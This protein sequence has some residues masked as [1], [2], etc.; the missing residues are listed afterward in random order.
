MALRWVWT[1]GGVA[2]LL[3]T[4]WG[5]G[6]PESEPAEAATGAGPA[7]GSQTGGTSSGGAQS[8]GTGTGGASTG[9][10]PTGGASTGGTS[11]G[12]SSG[13]SPT[14][15]ASTGGVPTGGASTGGAAAGGTSS[16]GT[17]TGGAPAG[18]T[19][20]GGVPTG[21]A[22]TGGT[23]TGGSSTGGTDTGGAGTGGAPIG[24]APTGGTNTGGA[25]TGG[26]STGGTTTGGSGGNLTVPFILGADISNTQQSTA[27]YRDTD[28]QEKSIFDLLK[29]HGFN[30]VRL[31]TF[32][33][34]MAPYGY[35]SN[36]NGCSGLSEAFGDKAHV[37]AYGKQVKDAGMGFLLDFHYSDNWADPGNQIIPDP[38]RD[39]A[40]VDALATLVKDYTKDVI[41]SAIAAGARP[42]M[43]QIGNE[44]TPGMLVHLPGPD[45]DCWGNN[46]VNA[47][48][49]GSSSS[50]N[51]DNLAKLLGAGIA[52]VR[53]VDPAIEIVLHIE[54]HGA[55]DWWV[56]EAVRRNVDFDILGLSCYVAFQGQPSVWQATFED[57]ASN[58]AYDHLDFIIAEYNPERTQANLIMKNLPDGR[59]RGTF[60]WEPTGSGEWGEAMFTWSGGV[61]VAN[62]DDFAEYDALLPQLGL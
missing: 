17:A 56:G 52:G 58:S 2:L 18:G 31:K 8:G 38:W 5:C 25:E 11:A 45:T 34:P 61:A 36:A 44:I 54:N 53:E 7:G 27:R 13:G 14:G 39:A 59:G 21:G 46:V 10:N 33:D 4:A 32:V 26:T 57:L 19:S 16:G 6:E 3:G 42:D 55:A 48:F 28:G 62:T 23:D 29:A 35:A 24:G 51:W 20:T 12:G 47:P 40:D 41:S 22:P 49:G 1:C 37:I 43:V 15:G 50:S 60:F 30:Y 9:G